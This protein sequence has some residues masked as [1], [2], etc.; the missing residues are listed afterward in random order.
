MI[1]HRLK[2]EP[3]I[4]NLRIFGSTAMVH[5]PKNRRL[6]WDKKSTRMILIG[7]ADNTKGIYNPRTDT[8]VT[9]RD[10]VVIENTEITVKI[11]LNPIADISNNTNKLIEDSVGAT[12]NKNLENEENIL[13]TSE[14]SGEYKEYI[15]DVKTATTIRRSERKPKP[16]NFEDYVTYLC[17]TKSMEEDLDTEPLTVTEA[18]RADKNKQKQAMK[19]EINSFE[20]NYAWEVVDIP[21]NGTV[22]DCKWVFK[23]KVVSMRTKYVIVCV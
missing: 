6:K 7:F 20:E 14:D 10:V 8:V 2:P 12:S 17:T 4:S 23:R 5:I 21:T 13:D 11:M 16:K 18:S 15:Q 22:V 1:K 19:K 9:S 3:D